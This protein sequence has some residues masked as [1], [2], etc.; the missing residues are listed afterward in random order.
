MKESIK[1]KSIQIGKA[2]Y[3]GYIQGKNV[4]AGR[5]DFHVSFTRGYG[6]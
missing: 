1:G 2:Y 4:I 3:E 5:R 6:N